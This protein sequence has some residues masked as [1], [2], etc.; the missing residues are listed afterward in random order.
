MKTSGYAGDPVERSLA[1]FHSALGDIEECKEKCDST[2]R[3]FMKNCLDHVSHELTSEAHDLFLLCRKNDWNFDSE[4][5]RTR[6]E[7]LNQFF[8]SQGLYGDKESKSYILFAAV[9]MF[10]VR[11][12]DLVQYDLFDYLDQFGF[13]LAKY[14]NMKAEDLVNELAVVS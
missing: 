10:S 1:L 9:R 12:E 6:V 13:Y 4:E 14:T 2:C 3:L 8:K 11:Q 7:G 5:I